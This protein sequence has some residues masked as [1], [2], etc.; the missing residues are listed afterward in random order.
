MA[1][2]GS[3]TYELKADDRQLMRGIDKAGEESTKRIQNIGKKMTIAVTGPILG[4]GAAVFAASESI[5]RAMATIVRGTGAAGLELQ[6]LRRDFEAVFGEVPG[7]SAQEV[8]EVIAGLNTMLGLT[9][10]ELQTAAIN[11][12]ELDLNVREVAQAMAIFG[13]DADEAAGFMDKL[14]LAS[15]E[16]GIPVGDLLEQLQEYGPVLALSLIHI[17]EP[18]RPY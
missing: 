2:L 11:A 18:T 16:T 9:G 4:I 3:A 5:D 7:K 12:L 6:Y 1:V 10:E 14:F 8:A 15:Q 13:V 17:S